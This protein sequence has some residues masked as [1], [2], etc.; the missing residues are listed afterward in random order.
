MLEAGL[1]KYCYAESLS[2]KHCFTKAVFREEG[3]L[4]AGV[5]SIVLYGA[6]A[7]KINLQTAGLQHTPEI[8]VGSVT[9]GLRGS[10]LGRTAILGAG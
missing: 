7:G 2:M 8:R 1:T 5:G 6:D 10:G 4:E 3:V 9:I